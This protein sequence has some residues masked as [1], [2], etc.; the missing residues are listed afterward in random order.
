M[1][2]AV[3]GG[4]IGHHF[5]LRQSNEGQHLHYLRKGTLPSSQ[6]PPQKESEQ[7]LFGMSGEQKTG[8]EQHPGKH[9]S[10]PLYQLNQCQ[11]S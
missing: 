2:P 1:L 9:P 7:S 10:H 6:L 3:E 5:Q 4:E 8:E 11:Q